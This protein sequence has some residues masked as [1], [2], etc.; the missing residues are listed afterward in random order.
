MACRKMKQLSIKNRDFRFILETN[1]RKQNLNGKKIIKGKG[2]S[3]EK[4]G[5]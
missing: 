5:I 3:N 2:A 4:D 1:D